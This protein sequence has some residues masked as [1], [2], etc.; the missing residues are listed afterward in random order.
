MSSLIAG[1]WKEGPTVTRSTTLTY[2]RWW[3]TSTSGHA[4]VSVV[5]SL[6]RPP[7]PWRRRVS[8]S[9]CTWRDPCVRV[10]VPLPSRHE[11]TKSKGWPGSPLEPS[12]WGFELTQGSACING[13]KSGW[14]DILI[15]P[16]IA[17]F[18]G[19]VVGRIHYGLKV[20]FC[21]RHFTAFHYHHDARPAHRRWSHVNA[22]K[23]HLVNVCLTCC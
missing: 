9:V 13:W 20:V 15:S 3:L 2:L 12:E 8:H 17:Q 4:V 19:C 10:Y 11:K 1:S 21:F 6:G 18:I 16:C 22:C 23:V 14:L 5:L 7:S